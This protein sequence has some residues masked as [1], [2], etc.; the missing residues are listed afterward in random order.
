MRHFRYLAV[1][2]CVKTKDRS[3]S[4]LFALL[5]SLLLMGSPSVAQ[6]QTSSYTDSCEDGLRMK[7]EDWRLWTS[8]TP[9]PIRSKGHS[10]N[11]VGIYVDELAKAT[12]QS[13]SSPYPTCARI[14]KPIYT[15]KSGTNVRK[16][17]IMVEMAPGYDLE[18]G[19]WWYATSDAS[20]TSV[21]LIS[22]RA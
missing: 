10:N 4:W 14:V 16:L 3:L 11:W 22:I 20:G 1:A 8:V 13:A 9:N 2:H 21:G 5:M 17:T 7:F 15:D 6:E 19:D 12:Y 18:N